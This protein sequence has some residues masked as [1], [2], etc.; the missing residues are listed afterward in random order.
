MNLRGY[1][2]F[3]TVVLIL[4]SIITAF[5]MHYFRSPEYLAEQAVKRILN[6]PESAQFR[7]MRVYTLSVCGEVNAKNAMG[8]YVGFQRFIYQRSVTGGAGI[9]TMTPELVESLWPIQCK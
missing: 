1:A 3:I 7:D 5:S 6:D 2:V 4:A 8:G 9:A